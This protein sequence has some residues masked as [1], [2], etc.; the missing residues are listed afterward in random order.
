MTILVLDLDGVVVRGHAEGGRWDKHLERDLGIPA[1]ALQ[2]KFFRP[3]FKKIVLGEA[4]LFD[5]LEKV[6]PE[7]DCAASPSSFVDYW[8]THDSTLDTDVLAQVD[9]WRAGGGK[10]YLATVQ[11]HH[12][13]RHVWS[14]LESHFD[15]M[16]YSAALGARKPEPAFYE[17]VMAKLPGTA[18]G[19][20]IFLDDQV[21]NVEAA[22]ALGWSARQFR[23]ADDLRDALRPLLS[24]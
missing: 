16:F 6:W 8:F 2:E 14:I 9:A 12:R 23:S 24:R 19:D 1:A 13:A 3:H 7:L 5:V 17:R 10:A 4:D 11:E 18:A 21:P 20:I 15:G 22:T